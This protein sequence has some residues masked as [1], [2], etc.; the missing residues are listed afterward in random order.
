MLC[1]KDRKALIT[2]IR[3]CYRRKKELTAIGRRLRQSDEN[4]LSDAEKRICGEIAAAMQIPMEEAF[5]Y[6][7]E[8]LQ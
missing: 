6:L 7:R 8:A 2:E 1:G 5:R 4:F 3:T